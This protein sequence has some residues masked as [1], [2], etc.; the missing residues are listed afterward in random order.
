MA[1]DIPDDFFDIPV[2]IV[3]VE[4]QKSD[5]MDIAGE[6]GRST[7]SSALGLVQQNL[8]AAD[9]RNKAL[10]ALLAQA[11]IQIPDHLLQP[12]PVAPLRPPQAIPD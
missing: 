9:A 11:Q 12:P 7:G 5:P 6:Y 8:D 10:L 2:P 1:H 4:E 3:P